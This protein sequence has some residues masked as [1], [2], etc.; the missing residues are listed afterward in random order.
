MK[1]RALILDRSRTSTRDCASSLSNAHVMTQWS[2]RPFA[3][4]KLA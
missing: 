4:D 2:K 1:D 3:G